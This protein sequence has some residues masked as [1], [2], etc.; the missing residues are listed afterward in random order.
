MNLPQRFG[1]ATQLASRASGWT[2]ARRLT[3]PRQALAPASLDRFAAFD[4][5]LRP[6][7]RKISALRVGKSPL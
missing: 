3:T 4:G 1:T 7:S 2:T 5:S 6:V